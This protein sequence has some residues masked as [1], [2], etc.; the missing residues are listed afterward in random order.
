MRCFVLRD[1]LSPTSLCEVAAFTRL[2]LRG[3]DPVHTAGLLWP[4][5]FPLTA[6]SRFLTPTW[7]EHLRVIHR[8]AE[9]SGACKAQH[10]NHQTQVAFEHLRRGWSKLRC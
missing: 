10:R 8:L 9:R 7:R 3:R 2:P 5:I 4:L 6:S 1:S